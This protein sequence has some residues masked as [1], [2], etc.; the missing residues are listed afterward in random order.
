V[1][2]RPVRAV[3]NWAA[4]AVVVGLL[5][6]PVA[7][8]V[9]LATTGVGLVATATTLRRRERLTGPGRPAIRVTATIGDPRPVG[10][11]R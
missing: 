10:G 7:T 9:V 8:A 6:R 11:R 3:G 5:W 1:V 4:T 2:T